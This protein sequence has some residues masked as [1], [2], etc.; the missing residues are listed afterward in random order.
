MVV[1]SPLGRCGSLDAIGPSLARAPHTPLVHPCARVGPAGP[2]M[3]PEGTGEDG[4]EGVGGVHGPT[5]SGWLLVVLCGASG[6]YCLAR[7]A[8]MTRL[9][10]GRDGHPARE[11]AEAGSEA[12]MGFGMAAMALPAA[13]LTPPAWSWAVYAVVF[14]LTALYGLAAVAWWGGTRRRRDRHGG[15][16]TYGGGSGRF[17]GHHLHHLVGSLAMVYMAV[18]MAPAAGAGAQGAT[19]GMAGA[20]ATWP[21]SAAYLCSPAS[22][23]CTSPGTRCFLA[24]GWCR[25]QWRRRRA[26][27]G[28]DPGRSGPEGPG[29]GSRS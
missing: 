6:V 26:G 11:P 16:G 4:P 28:Q 13:V 12:L 15:Y 27:A 8:R 2:G 22:C 24:R 10:R 3:D 1:R 20:T 14:G 19:G 5:V 17:Y 21:P 9:S 25:C 18:A 7:M 23:S 29:P